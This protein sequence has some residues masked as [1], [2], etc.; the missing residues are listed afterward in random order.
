MLFPQCH[1]G[2]STETARTLNDVTYL[3]KTYG[4][5]TLRVEQTVKERFNKNQLIRKP[6]Q[7]DIIPSCFMPSDVIVRRVPTQ[8]RVTQVLVRGEG[9][10]A[11]AR[12]ETSGKTDHESLFLISENSHILCCMVKV[13]PRRVFPLS[14]QV[15][16]RNLKVRGPPL[17]VVW[18]A[19]KQGYKLT[20]YVLRNLLPFSDI[21]IIIICNDF[22]G[23]FN[24]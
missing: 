20:V 6:R 22:L 16:G 23:Q 3:C 18:P 11:R 12:V 21:I 8:V 24:T 1:A 17:W 7:S 10:R 5:W 13:F 2:R 9:G 19:R 14:S 15:R 4:I